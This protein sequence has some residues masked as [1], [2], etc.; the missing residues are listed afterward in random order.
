[1]PGDIKYG[2]RTMPIVWGINA[3]K[4][5]VAVWLIVLL[6]LLITIQIYILQFK[7]WLAI[8]YGIV[9]VILPLLYIFYKLFQASTPRQ[10]HI[11]STLT[12]LVMLTGIL[13]MIFFRIY[14]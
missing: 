2:C 1:M 6:A 14:L 3:T 10:F 11:L 5:Y 8:A 13:S 12:K 7:W 9:M 4:V